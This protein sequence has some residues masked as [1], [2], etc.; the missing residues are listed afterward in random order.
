MK[1]LAFLAAALCGIAL[2]GTGVAGSYPER[3]VRMVVAFG[4][5]TSTDTTAR[6]FAE[7]LSGALG[8]AVIVENRA[9]AGGSIGTDYVAKAAPDGYTITMGTVGTLAINKGLYK[10]LPYDP[11]TSFVPIAMPGYTPTLLVTRANAPW[12]TVQELVAYAKAHPGTVTYASAGPGTSGHL[13]GA[14]MAE[15][16]KTQML[17]VP[18]KEGAQAVTAVMSGETDVLFY[19]PTAVMP[20]VKAGRLKA[21][22]A[23]SAR[24]SAAAPDVPTM[25]E[26]GFPGFDLTAWYMLA[27]P[28]GVPRDVLATLGKAAAQVMQDPALR[29]KLADLGVEPS[30]LDTAAL[31]PFIKTETAK[32]ADIIVQANAALD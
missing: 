21:L 27:A 20:Q 26:S 17:H 3:P 10:R 16:S 24:R 5:G 12:N 13:A 29:Q 15:M 14:M 32:W 1:P 22:A 31:N 7:K 19:H 4:P 8:Q 9:G 28:A 6:L 30:T 11:V 18:Y 25:Q 2:H 23:S